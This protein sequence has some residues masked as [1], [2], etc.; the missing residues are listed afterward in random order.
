MVGLSTVE[1]IH[2]IAFLPFPGQTLGGCFSGLCSLPRIC[3]VQLLNKPAGVSKMCLSLGCLDYSQ[4]LIPDSYGHLL[5]ITGYFHGIIHSMH[6]V[7]SVLIT[8]YNWYNSGHNYMNHMFHGWIMSFIDHPSFYAP[9]LTSTPPGPGPGVIHPAQ[10][11]RPTPSGGFPKIQN[12][13]PWM[14][15]MGN[16]KK[17]IDHHWSIAH[18]Y[19]VLSQKIGVISLDASQSHGVWGPRMT[20]VYGCVWLYRTGACDGWKSTDQCHHY[21]KSNLGF[22]HIVRIVDISWYIYS[23]WDT[24]SNISTS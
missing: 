10:K 4:R 18:F 5:V 23:Y 11:L 15:W 16:P 8:S 22:F 24:I 2:D 17:T 7:S 14:I 21:A 13:N 3:T 9:I 1:W 12:Q 20:M 6:G 19:V